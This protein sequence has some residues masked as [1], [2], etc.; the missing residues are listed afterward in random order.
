MMG[1]FA[2]SLC[3]SANPWQQRVLLHVARLINT[4]A[5]LSTTLEETD[6]GTTENKTGK[7]RPVRIIVMAGASQ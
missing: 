6:A 2:K 5:V 1:R 4:S 7:H 3:C